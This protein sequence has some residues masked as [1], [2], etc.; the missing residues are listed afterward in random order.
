VLKMFE[1]EGEFKKNFAEMLALR[2][3]TET[4]VTLQ[5]AIDISLELVQ[6]ALQDF[7]FNIYFDNAIGGKNHYSAHKWSLILF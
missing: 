7:P 5:D 4:G 6:K 2:R 1:E 3:E